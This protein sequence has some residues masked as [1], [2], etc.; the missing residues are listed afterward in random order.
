MFPVRD[1]ELDSST[2]TNPVDDAVGQPSHLAGDSVAPH[3]LDELKLKR[4]APAVDCE[5]LQFDRLPKGGVINSTDLSIVM[6]FK[7]YSLLIYVLPSNRSLCQ[8]GLHQLE[9]VKQ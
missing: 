6:A 2:A 5:N 8:R 4:R 9:L 7:T 3:H 1:G